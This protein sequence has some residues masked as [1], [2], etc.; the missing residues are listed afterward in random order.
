MNY[1][2]V[3]WFIASERR[4]VGGHELGGGYTHDRTKT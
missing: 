4:T 3:R 1:K 2:P